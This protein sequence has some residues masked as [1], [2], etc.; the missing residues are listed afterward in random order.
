MKSNVEG[1]QMMT[2]RKSQKIIISIIKD[3][4]AHIKQVQDA[5][6]K[7]C[8]ENKKNLSCIA[9]IKSLMESLEDKVAD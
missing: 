4:R 5:I 7:E 2:K 3:I 9:Q 1:M 6:K 8:S